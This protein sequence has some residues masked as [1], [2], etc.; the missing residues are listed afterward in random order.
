M[1]NQALT[2]DYAVVR[3]V[4]HEREAA[5]AVHGFELVGVAIEGSASVQEYVVFRVLNKR[6]GME[7]RISFSSAKHGLNGAFVVVITKPVDRRLN[8]KDFLKRHKRDDLTRFFSYRDPATDI[9]S[10]AESF[11]DM[12][13]ELF[14]ADLKRVLDGSTFE[15]TPIDW[16]GYK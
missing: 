16:A 2:G 9:R 1:M 12:L 7:V 13:L 4:L 6:T 11:L 3:D 8:V 5:F 15:D 14:D 10:F